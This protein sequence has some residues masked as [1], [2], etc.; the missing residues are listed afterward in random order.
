MRDFAQ[1]GFGFLLVIAIAACSGGLKMTDAR[2]VSVKH[3]DQANAEGE[4]GGGT[5]AN[6]AED[7]SSVE[8]ADGAAV[9]A[10]SSPADGDDGVPQA[11]GRDGAP[12]VSAEKPETVACVN[13]VEGEACVDGD[14]PCQIGQCAGCVVWACSDGQWFYREVCGLVC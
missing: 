4:V 5:L 10:E 3:P 7:G 11:A 9:D 2:D 8:S 13:A 1:T 14:I 6:A 12:D